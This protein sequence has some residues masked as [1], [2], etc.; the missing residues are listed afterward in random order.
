MA[1]AASSRRCAGRFRSA[2]RREAQPITLFD[3]TPQP[4]RL[5]VMLDVSGSMEGNLPLLRTAAEQL[6]ARLPPG[7]WRARGYV[8]ARDRPSVRRSHGIPTSFARRCQQHRARRAHAALAGDRQ[9]TGHIRREGEERRVILVLSDGKD[10][11]PI[12]FRQRYVSQ[13][14]VI[15]R[16]ARR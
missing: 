14:E 11:G 9:G 15:D 12:D 8:R 5:T 13:A 3:S 6:F 10:S 2:R 1:M 4:V 7:R 16:C